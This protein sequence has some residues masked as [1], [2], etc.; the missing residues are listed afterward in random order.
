M[1]DRESGE[2][3]LSSSPAIRVL[4]ADDSGPYLAAV[5]EVIGAS[6]GF[7]VDGAV[8]SGEEAV[9]LA[10][11]R[12]PDLALID[13]NMPGI[14]GREAAARIA[15]ASPQTAVVLMTA[16]PALA[17][18]PP[19]VVDKGSLTATT[20]VEIWER[21]RSSDEPDDRIGIEGTPSGL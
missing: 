4:V 15:V 21:A 10:A 7:V 2:T 12:S 18:P 6:D 13:L 17:T 3:G 11:L 9:E 19:A 16:V 1:T 14:G 20:L 8:R 5:V